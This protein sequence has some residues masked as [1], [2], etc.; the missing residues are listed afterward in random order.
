MHDNLAITYSFVPISYSL[1]TGPQVYLVA[2]LHSGRRSRGG[3]ETQSQGV[4]GYLEQTTK[5]SHVASSFLAS[6]ISS[7][8]G[9]LCSAPDGVL[10]YEGCLISNLHLR[11]RD[12]TDR[13][14]QP[15]QETASFPCT[16]CVWLF[17]SLSIYFSLS[18]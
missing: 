5:Q 7:R 16:L 9:L 4:P 14:S 18:P 6:F 17:P 12:L 2:F 15:I 10:P 1:E 3:P 11:L 13:I 8:N